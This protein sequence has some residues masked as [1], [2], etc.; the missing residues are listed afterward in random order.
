MVDAETIAPLLRATIARLRD[1][2]VETI[3]LFSGHFA[4]EQIEL[5]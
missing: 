4:G 3:V 1:F 5:I 2:G